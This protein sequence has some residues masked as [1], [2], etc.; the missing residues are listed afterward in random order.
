M[1]TK[2][3]T[4]AIIGS[5]IFL[6]SCAKET[7]T[8]QSEF[9]SNLSALC[10]KSFAGKLVS[11]DET[12]K[13]FAS[14][15]M[16]MNVR[17]CSDTEIRIPFHVDEDRSR[18]WIL[19]K[20][21][22]GLRLKHQHNHED[23]HA[24]DVTMYGGDTDAAGTATRQTFPVDQYSKDMFV[25]NGLDVS[26]TNIWAVEITPTIYAYELRRKG[27]HFRVEFDLTKEIKTPPA[28]W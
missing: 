27:R 2:I 11:T 25:Q 18:T 23:G 8:P 28:P 12:D 7:V 1:N 6:S 13:D 15:E 17:E 22:T 4:S 19:S 16:V 5:M 20:T 10:G 14:K 21:E 26:V 3:I 24:D 9:M